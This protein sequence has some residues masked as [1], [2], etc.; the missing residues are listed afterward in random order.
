M[1]C[2]RYK[3]L[4]LDYI[5]GTLSGKDKAEFDAHIA[6]CQECRELVRS[7]GKLS[8][9]VAGHLTDK[10]SKIE[11]PPYL[12]AKIL[13]RVQN[14]KKAPRFSTLLKVGI[15]FAS[16]VAV[17]SAGVFTPVFGK[18]GNLL[19]F[20]SSKVIENSANAYE[21]IFTPD[22][23]GQ[24]LKAY[25][26]NKVS[27]AGNITENAIWDMKASGLSQKE[28]AI[29][30]FIAK[31]SGRDLDLV[32]SE[33]KEGIGWGRIANRSG[34]SVFYVKEMIAQPI[35]M[36]TQEISASKTINLPVSVGFVEDG[37][38]MTDSI[39]EPIELSGIPLVDDNNKPIELQAIGDNAF[40]M[41]FKVDNG[42]LT[43]TSVKTEK[44][45]VSD[46]TKFA[47]EGKV[48]T[49][50]GQNLVLETDQGNQEISAVAGETVMHS[51]VAP[52]NNIRISGF[53]FGKRFLASA[54]T[55][56]RLRHM[57]GNKNI[58]DK[59]KQ[60]S[61]TQTGKNE[62]QGKHNG[63]GN[64]YGYRKN[65]ENGSN[66]TDNSPK[67]KND[68]SSNNSSGSQG[69]AIGNNTNGNKE[70]E[71]ET[72]ENTVVLSGKLFETRFVNFDRHSILSTKDGNFTISST[73]VKISFGFDIKDAELGI[74][75]SLAPDT[76]ISLTGS[77]KAVS[78]IIIDKSVFQESSFWVIRRKDNNCV[79]IY[80]EGSEFKKFAFTLPN[81]LQSDDI[82]QGSHLSNAL[83]SDGALVWKGKVELFEPKIVM[84]R[85]DSLNPRKIEVKALTVWL[86]DGTQFKFKDKVLS[87][88]PVEAKPGMPVNV[89]YIVMDDKPIA[90]VVD[91]VPPP[92]DNEN[93]P[94]RIDSIVTKDG[95]KL[96]LILEDG[97]KII[98]SP[99]VTKI[100][101][102]EGHGRRKDASIDDIKQ[103][104][105]VSFKRSKQ[106]MVAIEIT[107]HR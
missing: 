65:N 101:I 11:L 97:N 34:I 7:F 78:M 52:G 4:L 37:K 23:K 90:L 103:G 102:F 61:Q 29:A 6:S 8:Q 56:P 26:I 28:I 38:L 5:D 1:K 32:V 25:S 64:R 76:K 87:A 3:E 48:L 40:T 86:V 92:V 66:P 68:P 67:Q 82:R 94:L 16:I 22:L 93:P 47:F 73:S 96:E 63:N 12:W 75:N 104:L 18:E 10:A 21:E 14:Q 91:F 31:K 72:S 79:A 55:K 46:D 60:E 49:F 43:L 80:K 51:I 33:R 81:W 27:T 85:I 95:G 30:A 62:N 105:M 107:I 74:L 59:G 83:L 36:L 13:S 69:N 41:S 39:S 9:S 2:D 20:I 35:S 54:I 17:I 15:T 44:N 45:A 88:M 98:I 58:Q 50:D 42:E 57:M 70:K 19:N 77:N 89:S 84:G 53:K 71:S 106:G 99:G 100:F 24:V